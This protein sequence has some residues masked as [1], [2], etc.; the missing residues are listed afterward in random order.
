MTSEFKTAHYSSKTHT[1][2]D[3]ELD[4]PEFGWIPLTITEDE[5][6]DL[7][8]EV[9]A[10]PVGPYIPAPV[11]VPDAISFRQ[12]VGMLRI[13]H[14]ISP[15]ESE[16]WFFE[17]ILPDP[18]FAMLSQIEDPDQHFLATTAAVRPSSVD[19]TNP[20][21]LQLAQLQGKTD[22][23]MDAFFTEAAKL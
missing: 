17:G 1:H 12:L 9:V 10:Q 23:D 21:V 20:L 14:W 19:R 5:Y 11:P 4:H 6:P 18:V 8:R 15:K 7:W 3:L 2:I 13:L 22:A 16:D